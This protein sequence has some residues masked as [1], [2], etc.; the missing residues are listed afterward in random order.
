ME[1][2]QED[3]EELRLYPN[4]DPERQLLQSIELSAEATTVLDKDGNVITVVG[5]AE[6]PSGERAYPWML[7]SAL[8]EKHAKDAVRAGLSLVA[9]WRLGY[10]DKLLCNY[11][12]KTSL[13]NRAFIQ[14][15]GFRIVPAPS[16]DFDFFY[17]PHV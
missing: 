14:R 5:I 2:R 3:L 8:I 10:P 9:A 17:L 13:R 12:G 1:L 11:I 16:G 15:L 4:S 7:S 6:D